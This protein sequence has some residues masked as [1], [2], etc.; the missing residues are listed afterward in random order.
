[1]P[2]NAYLCFGSGDLSRRWCEITPVLGQRLAALKEPWIRIWLGLYDEHRTS[3]SHRQIS[4]FDVQAP[5]TL[6]W[7]PPFRRG[8]SPWTAP[9]GH[10]SI[11]WKCCATE[12]PKALSPWPWAKCS[13]DAEI[14]ASKCTPDMLRNVCLQCPRQSETILFSLTCRH[15]TLEQLLAL[16]LQLK[17]RFD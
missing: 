9:N 15:H 3:R 13:T 10:Q 17:F 14:A 8:V 16:R 7:L 5:V 11:G 12:L 6:N 2:I 4:L 1:M